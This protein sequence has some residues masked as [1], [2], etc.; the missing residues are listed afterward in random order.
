[1]YEK[2][3]NYLHTKRAGFKDPALNI[4]HLKNLYNYVPT[5]EIPQI[6]LFLR[7]RWQ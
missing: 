1:M 6:L 3:Y 5:S 7:L 4:N 2:Y